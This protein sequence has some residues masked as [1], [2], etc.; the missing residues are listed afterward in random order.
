MSLEVYGLV[1]LNAVHLDNMPLYKLAKNQTQCSAVIKSTVVLL[2]SGVVYSFLRVKM[3]F[4]KCFYTG[5]I[6]PWY[7]CQCA[8]HM[9]QLLAQPLPAAYHQSGAQ[10][11]NNT[12]PLQ[13]LD[14]ATI[15]VSLLCKGVWFSIVPDGK[16]PYQTLNSFYF[17]LNSTT[18]QM[19]IWTFFS[20]WHQLVVNLS[21][22]EG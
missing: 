21:F 1:L 19:Y 15:T 12:C 16:H 3:G 6:C 14:R 13:Q 22:H 18:L 9:Q 7:C 10:S 2:K 5:G 4:D 17:C 20:Y 8:L 11:R